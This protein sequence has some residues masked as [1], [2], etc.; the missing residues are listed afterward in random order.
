MSRLRNVAARFAQ[1]VGWRLVIWGGVA[2]LL[3]LTFGDFWSGFL[4]R[5]RVVPSG[6]GRRFPPVAKELEKTDWPHLRGPRYNGVSAEA[7][8]ADAWPPEGPPVLWIREI[9]SGYSGLIAV[10]SR[11]YTQSQTLY[12]QFVLCMDAET[13]ETIWEHHYAWPYDHGGMYPGPRATPTWN[14]GRVYFAGP[15]GVV[16]CLA[17]DDG[18]PIWSVNVVEKFGGR[19]ID[20][21]YSCTPLVRDGK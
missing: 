1:V 6:P 16:G 21:G 8:L 18:R 10:G 4:P 3:V 15:R 14:A 19:G 11:V 5:H 17:A 12:R 9:G 2:L 13:G 20:F 7:D